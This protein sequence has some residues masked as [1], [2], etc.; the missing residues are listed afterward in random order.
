MADN[1][2]ATDRLR[3]L[4]GADKVLSTD[5]WREIYARDASYFDIRPVCVA[6]PS[7]AGEVRLVMDTARRYGLG[8]TFRTGGTSLSGQTVGSGIICELRTQWRDY[9]VRDGGRRIW[10]QP[11]LTARQVNE[12]LKPHHHRIGPDPASS[13]AAM[14]GGIL[15]NNSSG[16]TAGVRYNSYHTLHSIEF[17]LTNGHRYDT[18]SAAD[19]RR[20]A[21]EEKELCRGLLD[22]RNEI[23]ADPE[24]LHR[25]KEKYRI[26]NVTGYAMNSFVDYSD[27]LDIFAHVLIGSEGTLAYI[28]SAE[29]DTLPL[30]ETYTSTLLY[31]PDVT[32]AAAS[33]AWLGETG[34]LAVEMMDYASLRSTQGLA[35]DMPAGTTAMLIDYGAGNPE[36]LAEKI[37]TLT[38]EIRKVKKLIHL[39]PFT[40]TVAERARL[41]Q[42]RDGVF[43]C[44]AGVRK[45]GATVILEDVAAPVERL[46]SLVEGV[47][48]LFA[49][50]GYD[51][52]IFG[53]ARDGNIHPLV[54]TL[55]DSEKEI[56][57]FRNFM[58]EF[59][60]HVLSLNGS[61]K[62]EHGTGRAIAPFVAREWGDDI[63]ALMCRL[64][65]LAD[66]GGILNPGVIINSDPEAFIKPLK[67]MDLF[68]EDL[69][70]R[71]ADKCIEC[72]YCEHVCPSRDITLTPR[73]RLQ[74]RRIIARASG[75]G[76][77]KEYAYIGA[78]TCC[79]DGSCQLPCP[80]GINT[81]V[82]TDAVRER[83]NPGILDKALT[84][85]A[86]RY[87]AAETAI[88]GV[89]KVAV[90]TEKVISPYP[91]I[92]ASDFLHR[93]YRQTPHWS[94]HFPMPA[95]VHYRELSD[96]DIIYFPACVT[97]IF[98]ASSL[99]KDDQIT[100][101][102]RIADRAGIRMAVP[103]AVH[104]LCC[105]Q[106]WEHKGD[107]EGQKITANKTVEEFYAMTDGGRI[108][109]VCDTTSCTHTLLE[110]GKN[111]N[112]FTEENK[113]KYAALKIK[114]ITLWLRDDAL[115]RLKVSR[116][117]H[118][119]LLH[120]T[121]ASRIM[122][123]GEAM[124][125]VARACAE[126]VTVPRSGY[127]CGAAGDRGFIFPEVARS[128][129][130][131]ERREIEGRTFDG[132]YSLAR[133][134]EI[135]MA[136]TMNRP[137]ESIVYL[138][139]ETTAP[140]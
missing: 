57:R 89:L 121:C 109:I 44:V 27:P 112:L 11:G 55:I 95:K 49:T 64:K 45:P 117:K 67:S 63:Y 21:E 51:G 90:A 5:L 78:D 100:V 48:R 54:T 24:M 124:A 1:H 130:R 102:L 108:P 74:A 47:Q 19:R 120:P 139:D 4:L 91:L 37:A 69:G 93:L 94:K 118:S 113:K 82:V 35:P 2:P 77:E 106:I 75:K 136:D 68:G 41:W 119:V 23:L 33:A 137:Y 13:Q 96:P 62:G 72:G 60:S 31:F 101:M 15:S 135:S 25:I 134:C 103:R 76:L 59:V 39:D 81:G 8:V 38:P 36:E 140:G 6:R 9:E 125:D 105:S 84:V 132:C 114:D 17:M 28:I 26:K 133:T 111:G 97:R 110:L 107:P 99:G 86:S 61:L 104:G 88:R 43:P 53:H 98:G 56:S 115:P 50:H 32:S 127:C 7:T 10:F 92:W 138:V 12:I 40:T 46:D 87:G 18:A 22:I 83:S 66:P 16:M 65:K 29:L 71:L 34:A 52:A 80:M 20:F 85:C 122:G 3:A 58:E 128:A 73:Q 79:S 123:V 42:I 30:Y 129:V 116:K 131:D 126:E 70:Y 14:M